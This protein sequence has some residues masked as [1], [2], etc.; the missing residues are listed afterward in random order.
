MCQTPCPMRHC[1]KARVTKLDTLLRQRGRKL[2]DVKISICPYLRPVSYD[3]AEQYCEAGVD[4]IIVFLFASD[5][6]ELRRTLDG[7]AE[8]LVEPARALQP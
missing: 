5:A 8:T 2:A 4:Q 3:A 6:D 1:R 7:L